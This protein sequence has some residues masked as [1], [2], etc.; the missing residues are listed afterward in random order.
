MHRAILS[1]SLCLG[2]G[3]TAF[4]QQDP[5][6]RNS[7]DRDQNYERNSRDRDQNVRDNSSDKIPSGT[8]IRVRTDQAINTQDH[9]DGRIFQGTVTEDVRG[10]D[11]R[12][13]IP[14]GARAELIVQNVGEHELTV[15]L[16]S[17]TVEGHRYMVS[18]Q[19]YDAARRSGV[20]ANERKGKYVGGGALFGTIIGAIAGGGKG[21]AIG[22]AAGAAAGAGAQVATR[23]RAINIPAETVLTF[24]LDQSLDITREP[25]LNDNGY[26]QDGNHYHNDY[27]HRDPRR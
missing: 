18:S 7:R 2:L 11:G 21:A 22:A 24:R 14:R 23:G 16:E 5:I 26:D 10:N 3:F 19:A 8:E 9:S 4:G 15:D 20:G 1:L 13:V 25:Y 6:D 12:M 27:Y 17:I